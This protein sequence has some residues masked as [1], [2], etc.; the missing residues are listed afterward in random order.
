MVLLAANAC[1]RACGARIELAVVVLVVAVVA[2]G[3]I[4]FEGASGI[5]FET[6]LLG[7]L[8]PSLSS[9]AL[10]LAWSSCKS[11]NP[12]VFAE[13]ELTT[14]TG[15]AAVFRLLLVVLAVLTNGEGEAGAAT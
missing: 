12:F 11:L 15:E 13:F 10:S 9:V 7:T 4:R 1:T 6:F 2:V 8:F 14:L 3:I 5:G